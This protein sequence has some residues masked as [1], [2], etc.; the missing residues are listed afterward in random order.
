MTVNKPISRVTGKARGIGLFTL[1]YNSWQPVDNDYTKYLVCFIQVLTHSLY[2][3]KQSFCSIWTFQLSLCTAQ[4]Y[5]IGLK[6]ATINVS[7]WMQ[8][9]WSQLDSML[10]I[11]WALELHLHACMVSCNI[12][13]YSYYNY[14]ASILALICAAYRAL[15]FTLLTATRSNAFLRS[16]CSNTVYV[17]YGLFFFHQRVCLQKHIVCA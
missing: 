13:M 4:H 15:G 6:G 1:P 10:N 7:M 9:T 16:C 5:N 14:N 11:P 3:H 2:P 17:D 8:C 12:V